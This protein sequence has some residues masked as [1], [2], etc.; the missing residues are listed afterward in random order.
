M[1]RRSPRPRPSE[2]T[3]PV[4][5]RG[6]TCRRSTRRTDLSGSSQRRP[7]T[8]SRTH[9]SH[10]ARHLA[11]VDSLLFPA[12]SFDT[13]HF[14]STRI[15]SSPL[16]CLLLAW[17]HLAGSSPPSVSVCAAITYLIEHALVVGCVTTGPC[18]RIQKWPP[19][20]SAIARGTNEI[21]VSLATTN[22]ST[23]RARKPGTRAR[24]ACEV[25]VSST[26]DIARL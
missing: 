24:H 1:S 6:V 13:R 21:A 19:H 16:Q 8:S 5:V 7:P 23:P 2:A 15:C 11:S 3:L 14:F 17:S 26:M 20:V 12:P 4:G 22:F 9:R 25:H 10:E 18:P